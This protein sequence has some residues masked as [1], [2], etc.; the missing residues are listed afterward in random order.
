MI[1]ARAAIHPKAQLGK[2][3]SV[4]PF[5]VIEENVTISD[6]CEIGPNTLIA[7]GTT[8]GRA[9]K[10]FHGACL[11]TA[12]QDL[13][14][15]GEPTRL[16]VGDDTVIREFVYANRGTSVKEKFLSGTNDGT[17]RIGARCLIM[18]YTHIAHDSLVGDEVVIAN[19]V[20]FGGHVTIENFCTIGGT[21]VVH[22]FGMVGAYAMVG[23][24]FRVMKDVPPFITAG[25]EPIRFEGVNSV[26]L[27]RRGFSQER[28]EQIKNVYRVLLR[29]GFNV[30]D[31]LK[32]IGNEFP[33][34]EDITRIVEFVKK[35][36]RGILRAG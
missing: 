25:S 7:R 1:D 3:I 13:K 35:S 26:G 32:K 28:I 15:A 4:G 5:A 31:A 22:Q 34:H 17:T 36:K 9:V 24:N 18:G 12:P 11:G 21:S 2:N 14:Y 30:S 6:D 23:G 29:S 8:L 20:Q 19:G 33:P 16:E 27:R 10:V